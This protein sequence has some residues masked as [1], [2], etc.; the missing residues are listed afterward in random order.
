MINRQPK[1][2]AEPAHAATEGQPGNPSV[3]DYARRHHF[4][5]R[6]KR[7]IEI[8]QQGSAANVYRPGLFI[9]NDRIEPR[10]IKHE[11]IVAGG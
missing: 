1:R 7:L 5:S 10:E 3:G 6:N 2:A 4:A 8:A 9:H 11:T